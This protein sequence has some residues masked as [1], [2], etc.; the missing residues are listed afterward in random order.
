[1]A[2]TS[3]QK[4]RKVK[5]LLAGGLVLGVGAAVTLAAWTD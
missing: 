5:A 4:S 2:P 1:M 3:S